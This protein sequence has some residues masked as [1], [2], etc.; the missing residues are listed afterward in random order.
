[1]LRCCIRRLDF[2]IIEGWNT[3]RQCGFIKPEIAGQADSLFTARDIKDLDGERVC[4]GR[5]HDEPQ[6]L[7]AT[8]LLPPEEQQHHSDP[9]GTIRYYHFTK[10][11]GFVQLD[12][13]RDLF[14]HCDA[15][16]G[17]LRNR[18]TLRPLVNGMRVSYDLVHTTK[19]PRAENVRFAPLQAAFQS[20]VY[21]EAEKPV[22]ED[23]VEFERIMSEKKKANEWQFSQ[24]QELGDFDFDV[25]SEARQKYPPDVQQALDLAEAIQSGVEPDAEY[26]DLRMINVLHPGWQEHPWVRFLREEQ[27][28]LAGKRVAEEYA[29]EVSPSAVL[30]LPPSAAGRLS[31]KKG[32]AK[33]KRLT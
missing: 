2:G 23:H 6:G 9:L 3:V 22:K 18:M 13:G 31:G 21:A 1:M 26:N 32:K 19:G 24:E 8:L 27:N 30:Q 17:A 12:D 33:R 25:D 14:F 10:G 15:A 20:V 7:V 11:Y 16:A 4:V 29:R 28:D 5:M